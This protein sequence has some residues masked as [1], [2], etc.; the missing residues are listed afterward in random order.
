MGVLLVVSVIIAAVS[1]TGIGDEIKNKMSDLVGFIAKRH[2]TARRR[3]SGGTAAGP[4][5]ATAATRAAAAADPRLSPLES[6]DSRTRR[7]TGGSYAYL[8]PLAQAQMGLG[9]LAAR[10]RR[11]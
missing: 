9:T 7:E 3:R 8:G 1:T 11:A 10:A 4:A 2:R 5:T 6:R